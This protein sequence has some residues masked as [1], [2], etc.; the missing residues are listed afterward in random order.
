MRLKRLALKEVGTKR[1]L[2]LFFS[3]VLIAG[4]TWFTGTNGYKFLKG[5]FLYKTNSVAAQPMPTPAIEKPTPVVT[6]KLPAN[7]NVSSL[8]EKTPQI[9]EVIG[10]LYIP[11]IDAT[12]PIYHGT[13]ED[14]LEKGVGHYKGSVLPGENDNT[15]LAGH[16]DTVFRRL[17]EVGVG[18]TLVVT[19]SAGTF[20]YK[21]RKVRIVDSDDRTVIVPKPK[22]TLTV[23]TCYPFDFIGDAPERYVL[24]ADLIG[25]K[26][27]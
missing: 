18:D 10:D 23:S 15:V 22:A 24:V 27:K 9:G 20:K 17:G 8:Y 5:Y 7:A 21:V 25:D 14:E 26:K 6:K 1:F 19:T 3:I 16:R 4:G 13:D 2:L 12:L 11:K